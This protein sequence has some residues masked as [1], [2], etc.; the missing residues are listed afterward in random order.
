[1]IGYKPLHKRVSSLDDPIH[2]G[3]DGVYEKDV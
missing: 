2:Q 1:M 3:I